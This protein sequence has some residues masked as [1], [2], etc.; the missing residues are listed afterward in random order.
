MVRAMSRAALILVLCAAVS[1]D[2]GDPVRVGVVTNLTAPKALLDRARR[3][4]IRVLEGDV[5]CDPTIGVLAFPNGEAGAREVARRDLGN[6]GCAV[7]ARFCGDVP[8]EKSDA[9][10]I[11]EARGKDDGGTTLVVGCTSAK[12][13]QDSVTLAIKMFRFL[14]PADCKDGRIQP[15][16]QCLA[17]SPGC[18]ETCRT[19]EVLLSQGSALGNTTSGGPRTKTDPFF[20]WPAGGGNAGRFFAFFTDRVNGTN[21]DVGVRA[22]SDA[23]EP[24]AA[25]PALRAGSIFLPNGTPF[26]PAQSQRNQSQPQAA[27][28]GGKYYVVFQDDDSPPANPGLDIHLRTLDDVLSSEQGAT[29]FFVN[30]SQTNGEANAQTAPSIAA[31]GSRLFVAWEDGG[32]IAGR[33]FTPPAT[34]ASQQALS[35][36]TGTSRP[37]V[38]AV[39]S[40]WVVVWQSGT[41]IQLRAINSDGTASGAEQQVNEGGTAFGPPRVASLPDGRFAV[42]WSAGGDVFLQRYDNRANKIAGDQAR[43]INDVVTDGDQTTPVV[44]ATSSAGGSYVIAWADGSTGHVRARFAGGSEGFLFNNGNGQ[45]TEFQASRDDGRTRA[46]PAVAS[47]G[48]GF[49]V[50]GWEDQSMPN[51]GVVGRKFPLPSE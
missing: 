6:T 13:D 22:M 8:V 9:L 1:C 29:P 27:F 5:T 51:P 39:S 31:S 26:P 17:G 20:L 24:V 10:R 7:G 50:I 47:G 45:S 25:P 12:V 35:T 3:L 36:T 40:G 34:V 32:R 15:T 43:P 37:Q 46:N 49:V 38:A 18:D 21:L 19:T 14:E 41:G 4:E 33:A 16:E 28:L 30:G 11:F 44:A 23:F 42:V 48:G 2:A